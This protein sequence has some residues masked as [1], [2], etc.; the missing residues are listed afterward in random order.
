MPKVETTLTQ[1]GGGATATLPS[2]A[3][4]GRLAR[5]LSD[6]SLDLDAVRTDKKPETAEYADAEAEYS[7]TYAR[8]DAVRA[9]ILASPINTPA[10]AVA[11]AVQGFELAELEGTAQTERAFARLLVA[12]A[13]AGN[14]P[15][16]DFLSEH[17]QRLVL[18]HV[19]NAEVSQ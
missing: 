5:V 16:S 11:L 6:R 7:L 1:G 2:A 3:E 19:Y 8:L 15:L 12:T 10:D 17:S 9:L 4:L 14:V 13:T 18:R